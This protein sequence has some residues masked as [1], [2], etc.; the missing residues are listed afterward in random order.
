M[1]AFGSDIW[2]K[3]RTCCAPSTAEIERFIAE[4]I[5]IWSLIRPDPIAKS[6]VVFGHSKFEFAGPDDGDKCVPAFIFPARDER[7]DVGALPGLDGFE[8][9]VDLV[10]W[11]PGC[12]RMAAWL[13]RVALL[14][15]DQVFAPRLSRDGALSVWRSPLDWLRNDRDG[16]VVLHW[17][18]A[19]S[20]L[21]NMGPLRAEDEAH[22]AT[23]RR[24][25]I[26][27]GPRVLGGRTQQTAPIPE[28][29]GVQ[30]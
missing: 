27:R 19:A 9:V 4:G 1:Q 6:S 5:S 3:F 28:M 14:G 20:L 7:E 13:G 26:K 21:Q 10:A 12:D 15:Q 23:L 25:L 2:D 8:A 17:P 11:S 30:E 18:G 16:V 29:A 24:R 22:T